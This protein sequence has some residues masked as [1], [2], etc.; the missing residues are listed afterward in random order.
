MLP[1]KRVAA[2]LILLF[3]PFASPVHA[4]DRPA[5]PPRPGAAPPGRLEPAG[6]P[7]PALLPHV[8]WSGPDSHIAQRGYFRIRDDREWL[9]IWQR[10]SGQDAKRD[11]LD[12][13]YIPKIN[14][15]TCEVIA[16]FKGDKYNSNGVTIES[17]QKTAD[18]WLVRF[19]ESTYQ[20]F[21]PDGGGVKV[22]PYGLFVFPKREG[23]V[24]LEENVQGLIGHPPKWKEQARL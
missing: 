10:H 24:I 11:N 1:S 4:Q 20:T 12:R 19:D 9:E 8:A 21:G 13:P 15:E 3:A 17:V 14:F 5:S 6:A 22:K 2:S 23:T 16:I 18:G 7:D